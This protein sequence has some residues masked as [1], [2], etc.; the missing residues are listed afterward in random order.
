MKSLKEM[1]GEIPQKLHQGGDWL[2][3]KERN[4]P[5]SE[6]IVKERDKQN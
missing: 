6:T 4:I 1:L 2:L 5:H 3:R